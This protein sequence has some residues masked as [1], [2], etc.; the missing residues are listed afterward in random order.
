MSLAANV[1]S[2]EVGKFDAQAHAFWD[3][4][5]P[6]RTLHA[7]NPLRLAYVR[8]RAP[9]AGSRVAD[10]GC[11]GG[12]LAEGLARAG[13]T[14]TAIDLAPGM[15]EV[16]ALHAADQG[17]DIDYRVES[18]E[19]LAA[20]AARFDVVTCMEMIEHVPDPAGLLRTLAMLLRPGGALFI[21]TLNRT[22]AAFLLAIVGAE[23]LTG[24]VPRGTHQYARLVR[25]AELAA[26]G[27]AARLDLRDIAGVQFNPV[28]FTC[29]LGGAPRIN[30]LAHLQR[31]GSDG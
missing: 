15:I 27:R 21:S 26:W 22:P 10:I 1:N 14:V 6:F 16:A 2:A 4:A 7:L 28:S 9:L 20:R 30:Y 25:P 23:Y 19:G 12:L 17:L 11:G 24:L 8:E 3:P 13:G 29:R 31:P 18:V 5:G